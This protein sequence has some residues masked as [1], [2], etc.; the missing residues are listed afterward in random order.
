MLTTSKTFAGNVES[1]VASFC[2]TYPIL[3]QSLKSWLSLPKIRT[4][5]FVGFKSPKMHFISVV[6]PEPLGPISPAKSPSGIENETFKDF[7]I[8]ITYVFEGIITLLIDNLYFLSNSKSLSAVSPYSH[9][10]AIQ[11][12]MRPFLFSDCQKVAE[13]SSDCNPSRNRSQCVDTEFGDKNP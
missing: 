11:G 2:A 1:I 7:L 13:V 3:S 5:P 8:V 10:K 9:A 4:E 6:F 12:T